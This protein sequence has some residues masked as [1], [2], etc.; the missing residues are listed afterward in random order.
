VEQAEILVLRQQPVALPVEQ[1][2]RR[3]PRQ[4]LAAKK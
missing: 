3:V 4:L 1:L 2:L